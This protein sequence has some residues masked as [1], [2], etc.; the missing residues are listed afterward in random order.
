MYIFFFD[1]SRVEENILSLIRLF[2]YEEGRRRFAT[3]IQT[4]VKLIYFYFKERTVKYIM[5]ATLIKGSETVTNWTNYIRLETH[6]HI[7][8]EKLGVKVKLY[9]ST[10]LCL[11]VVESTTVEDFFWMTLWKIIVM[12]AVK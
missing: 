2:C 7:M 3:L 1:A 4:L 8:S 10:N 6:D 5:S 11:E 12:L 9:K